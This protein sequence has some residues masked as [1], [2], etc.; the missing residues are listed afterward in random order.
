MTFQDLFANKFTTFDSFIV[1]SQKVNNDDLSAQVEGYFLIEDDGE[2][3]KVLFIGDYVFQDNDFTLTSASFPQSSHLESALNGLIKDRLVDIDIPFVYE[4]IRNNNSYT[5]A[6]IPICDLIGDK[7]DLASCTNARAVYD[8]GKIRII[9]S[10]EGYKIVGVSTTDSKITQKLRNDLI[11]VITTQ[12]NISA[13]I[14]ALI[15]VAKGDVTSEE[16]PEPT[17]SGGI[18]TNEFTIISKF[19]KYLDV[20]PQRINL[21]DDKYIV[22][23]S[24]SNIEFIAAVD[25]KNNYKV[26]PIAIQKGDTV[27]RVN[28]LS[29]NLTNAAF[30]EINQFKADP[31]AYIMKVDPAAYQNAQPDTQK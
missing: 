3:K 14:T 20:T 1:T 17:T 10:F 29:L 6:N 31:W 7:N 27:I 26:F 8:D 28:N 25:I 30:T 21:S 22:E 24:L 12:S 2:E 16:E 5:S 19:K 11:G 23:F 13:T 9:I 4:F 15:R 18:D